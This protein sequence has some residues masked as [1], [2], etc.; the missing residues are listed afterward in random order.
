MIATTT[1]TE[2]IVLSLFSGVGGLDLGF[3]AQGLEIAIA[4]EADENAAS[5]YQKNFPKTKV[6]QEDISQ[7]KVKD[8]AKLLD[9]QRPLIIIGGPPCQGFS[10]AGTREV[11]DPRNLMIG[12][13]LRFVVELKP[14]FFIMENV[15]GVLIPR[16]KELIEGYRTSVTEAG[17]QLSEW[18]LNAV[19]FGVPQNRKRLFW[20]G[21][22]EEKL[23]APPPAYSEPTTVR[24]AIADLVGYD[25]A[26]W[27]RDKRGE[28]AQYLLEIFPPITG[29]D[30]S[31]LSNCQ[32]TNHSLKVIKRFKATP[33][34]QLEPISHFYRLDWEGVAPTVRAGGRDRHT[35]TRPIH[36]QEHRVV[37]PREAARLQSFPDWFEFSTPKTHAHQQIGNAVPP[38]LA[39]FI[40]G[41]V[42]R[43][44]PDP[45]DSLVEQLNWLQQQL[46]EK[47]K[48]IEKLQA[49]LEQL[50]KVNVLRDEELYSGAKVLVLEDDY[51]QGCTG[52]VTG[53]NGGGWWVNLDASCT[54]N[55]VISRVVF[56]AR[57]LTAN[58][59]DF[60]SL[61]F[62]A[63][64][65]R[66]AN[67]N[68]RLRFRLN[69]LQKRLEEFETN[70]RKAS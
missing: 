30:E 66:Y 35:A 5:Q 29:W 14:T 51:W 16:Y 31:R 8:I 33:N 4:I 21:G 64:K 19:D 69:G 38:L 57:Q 12:E 17:Y 56:K 9:P 24:A 43:S 63:H 47:D 27:T 59:P 10:Q 22:L 46:Q 39:Y 48:V 41:V 40:A 36:P 60:N 49:N 54:G 70:E 18:V 62:Q 68:E 58:L 50:K 6:I 11:D 1:D 45:A 44:F 32:Q 7:V 61:V 28:F 55:D 34:G 26:T 42:K 52:V 53:R 3:H 23:I 15:T 13:F 67:E 37:T 20:V 65:Q 25:E 2:P